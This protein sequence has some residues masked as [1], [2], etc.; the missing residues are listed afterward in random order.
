MRSENSRFN[1]HRLAT[2][3]SLHEPARGV[4]YSNGNMCM[5]IHVCR[6]VYKEEKE[7]T[8]S[9]LNE[10]VIQP[11]F[12]P[13]NPSQVSPEHASNPPCLPVPRHC[14]W[15]EMS[16]VLSDMGSFTAQGI[17]LVLDARRLPA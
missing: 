4:W 13:E 12:P 8:I 10:E 14:C 11:L 16:L 1:A 3:S 9:Q 5:D 17:F 2:K 15:S 7:S 6:Y